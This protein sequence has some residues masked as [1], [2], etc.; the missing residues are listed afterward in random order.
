M[1]GSV[2]PSTGL[3]ARKA[4]RGDPLWRRRGGG[5]DQGTCSGL[6]RAWGWSWD[7]VWGVVQAWPPGTPVAG[8]L[9]PSAGQLWYCRLSRCVLP[10]LA[11]STQ[12]LTCMQITRGA[13]SSLPAGAAGGTC[14]SWHLS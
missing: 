4:A 14:I 1:E 13:P 3:G 2:R 12:G 10:G 6:S 5:P 9:P 11:P 7:G 8:A